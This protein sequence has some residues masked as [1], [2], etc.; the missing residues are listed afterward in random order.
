MLQNFLSFLLGAKL[1]LSGSCSGSGR[2]RHVDK[3]ILFRRRLLLG[4]EKS[5]RSIVV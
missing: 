1:L 5:A 3:E 2:G 4:W